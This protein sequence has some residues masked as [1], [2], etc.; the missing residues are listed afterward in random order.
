MAQPLF[1]YVEHKL[2]MT[3]F[4]K[5]DYACT[6]YVKF[7]DVKEAVNKSGVE[8]WMFFQLIHCSFL[9]VKFLVKPQSMTDSLAFN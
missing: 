5:F 8:D 9:I 6:I 3:S 2:S 4:C 1:F 7:I